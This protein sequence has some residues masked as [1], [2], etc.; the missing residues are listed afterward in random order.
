MAT[1]KINVL[2][3]YKVVGE[4]WEW[5]GVKQNNGY[6]WCGRRLAHRATYEDLIGPIPDGMN[7]L[8]SCDNRLCI[9]LEHLRLGTQ[10]E[11]IQEMLRKNRNSKGGW[12]FT[13]PPESIERM[14]LA[15]ARRWTDPNYREARK[16]A[17]IRRRLHNGQK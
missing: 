6:G 7:V 15:A 11:N 17:K 1:P 4:C 9:R 12:K 8:H 5:T 13:R 16:A 3:R 14:K 2:D 10:S